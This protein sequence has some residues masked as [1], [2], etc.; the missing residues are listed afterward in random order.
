MVKPRY[1]TTWLSQK[2]AIRRYEKQCALYSNN[3]YRQRVTLFLSTLSFRHYF[4][5]VIL[6]YIDD[7][8][9]AYA[10]IIID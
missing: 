1:I 10:A 8:I 4:R 2:Q 9:T 6:A 7:H 5:D 3:Q